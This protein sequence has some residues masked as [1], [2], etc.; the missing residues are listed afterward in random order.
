[1]KVAWTL[2]VTA[3]VTVSSVAMLPSLA[4]A[5]RRG[6]RGPRC[7]GVNPTTMIAST[8]FNVF[9]ST[10]MLAIFAPAAPQPSETTCQTGKQS[11]TLSSKI[12]RRVA[13]WADQIMPDR[14]ADFAGPLR[15]E[16]QGR[17]AREHAMLDTPSQAVEDVL[18]Q[19]FSVTYEYHVVFTHDDFALVNRS[20]VDVLSRQK[21]H[22]RH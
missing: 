3:G 6:V 8:G 14:F 13:I 22:K 10:H 1:M 18:L 11:G 21:P 19:S 15:A 16:K 5:E 7:R 4:S 17:R 20:L 12:E 9:S 2:Q